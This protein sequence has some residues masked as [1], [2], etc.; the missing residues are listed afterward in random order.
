M[1]DWLLRFGGWPDSALC[2]HLVNTKPPTLC[3]VWLM[4]SICF[5]WLNSQHVQ[6]VFE[7]MDGIPTKRY[8]GTGIAAS[9]YDRTAH[10]YVLLLHNP[11]LFRFRVSMIHVFQDF[12]VVAIEQSFRF[13]IRPS[14]AWQ[15]FVAWLYL[16]QYRRCAAQIKVCALY[17]AA[18]SPN[19]ANT[20][21]MLTCCCATHLFTIHYLGSMCIICY[22]VMYYYDYYCV[23]AFASALLYS[24]FGLVSWRCQFV[25]V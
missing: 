25:H 18:F 16:A 5:H 15:G 21:V 24:W 14:L 6:P 17:I 23:F 13:F 3:T 12:Y 2:I 7:H 20:S 11:Q 22:P 4:G 10:S 19:L 9:V 1:G 8:T